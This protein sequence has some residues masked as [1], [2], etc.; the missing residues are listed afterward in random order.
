ME[1][2]QV[3]LTALPDNRTAVL[4]ALRLVGKLSLHDA[5]KILDY[6]RERGSV[7]LVAGV[8]REVADH[9]QGK[10]EEA[11]AL[12]QVD[13]SSIATPMVC[14]PQTNV[15]FEWTRFGSIRTRN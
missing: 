15:P 3:D 6:V 2:Y 14:L 10:L 7:T 13:V 1:R 12:A 9:I 8:D 5:I 11:G 4:K